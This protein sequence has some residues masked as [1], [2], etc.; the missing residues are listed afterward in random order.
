MF[1]DETIYGLN[2]MFMDSVMLQLANLAIRA[3]W[4][5]TNTRKS[6]KKIEFYISGSI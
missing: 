1:P 4:N 3:I 6:T 5:L 2:V